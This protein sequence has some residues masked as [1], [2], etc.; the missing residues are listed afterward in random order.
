MKFIGI[1]EYNAYNGIIAGLK[2]NYNEF[3]ALTYE[4]PLLPL[5]AFKRA[6]DAY[7]MGYLLGLEI[8]ET[9]KKDKL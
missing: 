9:Y 4:K 5:G 7:L 8:K 1:E 6:Q 3:V 2:G